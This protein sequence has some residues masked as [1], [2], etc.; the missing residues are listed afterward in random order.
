MLRD[1]QYQWEDNARIYQQALPFSQSASLASQG[2]SSRRAR[3]ISSHPTFLVLISNPHEKGGRDM[4][5]EIGRCTLS[6]PSS[7]SKSPGSIH[8]VG[9]G[10][11]T[12]SM[13]DLLCTDCGEW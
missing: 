6:P 2:T 3:G 5:N 7:F 12:R 8:D 11:Y 1:G 9:G 13:W 10:L 4:F